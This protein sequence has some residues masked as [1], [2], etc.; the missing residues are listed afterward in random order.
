M[1]PFSTGWNRLRERDTDKGATDLVLHFAD[2]LFPF[3]SSL[4]PQ[5]TFWPEEKTSTV[6]MLRLRDEPVQGS[7]VIIG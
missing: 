5:C 2:G 1:F 6:I 4:E 7:A 3:G